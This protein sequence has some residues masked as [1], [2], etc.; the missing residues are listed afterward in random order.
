VRK[1]AIRISLGICV[2][3]LASCVSSSTRFPTVSLGNPYENPKMVSG[4]LRIPEGEGP[5]PAVVLLHTCGGLKPHVTQHWPKY[6]TGLGYAVFTV[7]SYGP[8]GVRYCTQ[9]KYGSKII[10]AEDALGALDYL[11]TL[12]SVD[13]NRVGVM[14]FSTGAIA[15][16]KY[17]VTLVRKTTEAVKFKAAIAMYGT[18][19][20][21][22][23]SYNTDS[24]PLMVIAGE[25]DENITP[26]C[27]SA[28]EYIPD[29]EVQ[30]LPDA[31]HAFDSRPA[32]GRTDSGGN[33]MQ[34]S[35]FATNKARQL[36]K[37]FFAKHLGR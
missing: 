17:I 16:N 28:A 25:R 5:F 29:I 37:E 2:I 27:I 33:Y 30:V 18:C 9:I 4:Y 32:S 1:S 35:E 11:A 20:G 31:H 24:V 15:I 19:W 26:S 8:R 14:G 13:A 10:Q 6:L 21:M 3:I 23:S 12:P 34:Y 36:T 7:D 22:S